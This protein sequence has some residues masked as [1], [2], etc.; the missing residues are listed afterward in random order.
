MLKLTAGN[1]REDLTDDVSRLTAEQLQ[2]LV[3]WRDFYHKVS[4]ASQQ[5]NARFRV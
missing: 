4:S 5:G 1:F 3:G 2:S